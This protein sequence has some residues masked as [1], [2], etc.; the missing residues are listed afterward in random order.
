VVIASLNGAVPPH[1]MLTGGKHLAVKALL[2]AA[3]TERCFAA[4]NMTVSSDV[5]IVA[6]DN[7]ES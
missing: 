6:L 1:V 7:S 5:F 3:V 4:L 2:S